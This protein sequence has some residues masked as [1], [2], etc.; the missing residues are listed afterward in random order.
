MIVACPSCATRFPAESYRDAHCPTCG[1]VA[2]AA[3]ART[4]PRCELPLSVRALGDVVADECTKCHGVFIDHVAIKGVL[5]HRERADAFLAALPRHEHSVLTRG[6]MYIPCPCCGNLMNRKLFATGSGVIVD[7]CRSDGMF[8]D[9]GELPAII[10]F[11]LAGGLER[12]A[13]RDA[14]RAREYERR[15]RAQRELKDA[16]WDADARSVAFVD[17]LVALFG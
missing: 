12:A 3:A 15:A 16:R 9:A 14:E 10:D 13:A 6:R 11:V 8:F 17:L 1:A 5:D 2:Q 7:V 4:C